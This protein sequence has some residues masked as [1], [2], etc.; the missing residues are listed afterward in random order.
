MFSGHLGA[1]SAVAFTVLISF[2]AVSAQTPEV[3]GSPPPAASADLL[4]EADISIRSLRYDTTSKNARLNVTGVNQ[5]GG[6][7]IV[8]TNLPAHPQAGKTYH[9]VRIQLQAASRFAAPAATP[10]ISPR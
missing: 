4:I 6:Y 1:I 2:S 9:N 3:Q 5:Q 10:S 7:R 8:R